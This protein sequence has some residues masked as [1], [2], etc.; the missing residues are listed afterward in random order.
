VDGELDADFCSLGV[1]GAASSLGIRQAVAFLNVWSEEDDHNDDDG[2]P[3]SF[4]WCWLPETDKILGEDDTNCEIRALHDAATIAR[5]CVLEFNDTELSIRETSREERGAGPGKAAELQRID[6]T[7]SVEDRG[8][9]SREE[10]GGEV[11]IG[12]IGP[13]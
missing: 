13:E 9:R 10:K 12:K 5:E 1:R 2:S 8:G 11:D 4:C 6:Q 7:D 3:F